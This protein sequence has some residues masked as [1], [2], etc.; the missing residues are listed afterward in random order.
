MVTTVGHFLVND[1]LP[2]GYKIKGTVTNRSLHDLV[3]DLAKKDPHA[4]VQ[5]ISALKRR[6][7]E[8]ATLEGVTVGIQDIRPDYAGREA[9]LGPASEKFDK[10][11]TQ[12]EKTRVI[13]DAQHQLLELTKRHPGSMTHMAMSGARGNLAQLMKIVTTPLAIQGKKG[14]AP[15]M[16]RRSYAEGLSPGEYWAAAPEARANNVATVVS[17]SQPG[18][19]AKILV[20]NM[21]DQVVTVTDCGTHAGVRLSLDDVHAVDRYA[22]DNAAVPRNTLLTPQILARLRGQGLHDLVV[23]SPMT[24]AATRGVCQMCQGL[25]EKGHHHQ[26][27]TNIGVRAAQAMSE[28]LTQFALSS[29]HAV[30]TVKGPSKAPTGLKAVRQLLEIPKSFRHEAVLAP[31]AG[32]VTK[33]EVAAQGGHYV[34][35][36]REKLYV[37]PDLE[38]I[39]HVGQHVERGDSLT[40]GI[41]NPATLTAAKGLGAGRQYFVDALHKVYKAEGVNLDRRHLEI[42]A[43]AEL[44]HVRLLEHDSDHPELMKGDIVSYNALRDA[45]V[46]DVQAMPVDEAVGLA[47]GREVL[48]HTVGT[49]LTPGLIRELKVAGVKEV[50]AHKRM[51]QIEAIMKPFASN[52]ML[53]PDWIGRL[54]HRG[55]KDSISRAVHTGETSDIHGLNPIAAYTYGVSFGQGSG[56]AY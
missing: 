56:G 16:I 31:E 55:L 44:N 47:L 50:W 26:V 21:I 37:E 53:H 35:V 30:L 46:R 39:S 41:P 10:A 43:R 22:Q 24:C 23:R 29:K 25:D 34:Y 28:P 8:I 12:D 32:V 18:E 6:G 48:H 33:T 17:V 45:Y 14:V 42:L 13:V 40:T 51:P 27:G 2:E 38:L 7:D 4:Y 11:K 1:V 36:N 3:V 49:R 9:I 52:P 20:A 15:L 19:M 54:A 5:A